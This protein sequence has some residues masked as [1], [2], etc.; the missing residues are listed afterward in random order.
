MSSH[1]LLCSYCFSQIQRCIEDGKR[2]R[3][4]PSDYKFSRRTGAKVQGRNAWAYPL[5]GVLEDLVPL[6]PGSGSGSSCSRMENVENGSR[7]AS[8]VLVADFG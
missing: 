6:T 8:R 2:G 1:L 7:S 5:G 4:L 3:F